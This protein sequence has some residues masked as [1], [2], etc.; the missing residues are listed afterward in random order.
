MEIVPQRVK[1]NKK[2]FVKDEYF[3]LSY[4]LRKGFALVSLFNAEKMFYNELKIIKKVWPNRKVATYNF[5]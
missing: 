3:L 4:V 1:I 5:S 2:S